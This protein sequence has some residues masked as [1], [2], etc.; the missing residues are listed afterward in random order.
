[1]L[2][3]SLIPLMTLTVWASPV[4]SPLPAAGTSADYAEA[5]RF[6]S[7]HRGIDLRADPGTTVRAV[8]DGEVAIAGRVAGK[9]VIV[10]LVDDPNGGRLRVTYEP[11]EADV[12]VGDLVLAGKPLGTL[13]P[14]GGH[15]GRTP[16]CL[17][18]G[19]KQAGHYRDPSGYLGRGS[20]VLKP[21]R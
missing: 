21:L 18:L 1:M 14:E 2:T 17:H 15:C 13:A 4:P 10:L 11:V 7:G 8:A 5:A 19:V 9:P 20:I 6:G 12:T 3:W 16:H